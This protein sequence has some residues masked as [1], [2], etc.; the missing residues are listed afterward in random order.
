VRDVADVEIGPMVRRGQ[1]GQDKEDD[2]VEGIVLLRRGENPFTGI[3]VNQ[4][5]LTRH[6]RRPATRGEATDTL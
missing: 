4:R 6:Y 5:A 2:C 3:A 1:V